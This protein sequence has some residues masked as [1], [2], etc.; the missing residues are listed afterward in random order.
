[1]TD[2]LGHLPSNAPAWLANWI[3]G[4]D[5][6]LKNHESTLASVVQN[7]DKMNEKL[8]V[9]LSRLPPISNPGTVQKANGVSHKWLSEKFWLPIVFG[10]M[11][12]LLGIVLAHMLGA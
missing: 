6:R 9:M 7:Q 11:L 1:M 8:D 5:Q 10:G 4:T 2:D 12:A 3:G